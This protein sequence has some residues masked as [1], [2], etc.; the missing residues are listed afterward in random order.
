[1]KEKSY[2]MV[3]PQ[4]ANS[5]MVIEEVTKRLQNAGLKI[6]QAE[7]VRYDAK[8]A[9]QHYH[10]HVEKDFYPNL[11]AYITSDKVYGMIVEGENAI[12]TIRAL[13]GSTKNSAPGTIRHDIPVKLGIAPRVTENVVHASDCVE[14]AE[15]ESAIFKDLVAEKQKWSAEELA[16]LEKY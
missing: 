1:M 12:A 11:E 2:V 16:D 15:K 9:R 13:V 8:H 7:F 10:E 5:K 4:F 14:A 3:K 6:T